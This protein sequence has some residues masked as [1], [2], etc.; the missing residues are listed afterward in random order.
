LIVSS[1]RAILSSILADVANVSNEKTVRP[2]P[3]SSEIVAPKAS[4][5]L[6]DV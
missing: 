2:V 3:G 4:E 5:Y 6:R 1:S